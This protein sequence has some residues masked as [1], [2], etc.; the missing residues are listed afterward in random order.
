MMKMDH[1]ME[2]TITIRENDTAYEGKVIQKLNGR[3]KTRM[4][5]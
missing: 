2:R 1:F 4:T 3:I 5:Q